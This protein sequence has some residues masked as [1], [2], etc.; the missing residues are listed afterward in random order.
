M[1][2]TWGQIGGRFRGDG[3]QSQLESETA[4]GVGWVSSK[5]ASGLERKSEALSH[6]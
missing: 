1:G 5:T 2:G 4:H 3:R 6:A